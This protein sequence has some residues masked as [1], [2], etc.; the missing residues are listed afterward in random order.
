MTPEEEEARARKI[1]RHIGIVARRILMLF[2]YGMSMG[3]WEAYQ[4]QAR[5]QKVRWCYFLGVERA[6]WELAKEQGEGNEVRYRN[7]WI[8]IFGFWDGKTWN[9]KEL[10][11]RTWRSYFL[12]WWKA[13]LMA[14]NPD[15]V[16]VRKPY[17]PRDWRPERV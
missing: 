8:R 11:A 12:A 10:R 13:F 1:L 2:T 17:S 6:E 5:D 9:E 16:I 3:T 15:I 7:G 14:E 4:A